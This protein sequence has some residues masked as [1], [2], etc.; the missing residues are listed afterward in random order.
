MRKQIFIAMFLGCVWCNICVGCQK[1]SKYGIERAFECNAICMADELADR[2]RKGEAIAPMTPCG[3][4]MHLLVRYNK[5]DA[6]DTLLA[7]GI[8]P[9]FDLFKEAIFYKRDRIVEKLMAH[10]P[11]LLQQQDGIG[12]P[13]HW[14]SL[15][16][17]ETLTR[18]FLCSGVNPNALNKY[19]ETP[20]HI[21]VTKGYSEIVRMLCDGG[22]NPFIQNYCFFNPIDK[23]SHR[24]FKIPKRSLSDGI[25]EDPTPIYRNIL[26][27]LYEYVEKFGGKVL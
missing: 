19:H 11:S 16:K 27:I 15:A 18:R 20:L 17:S 23:A 1:K 14:A 10:D 22:A 26:H 9:T 2:V 12:C 5:E 7:K 8:K 25:P 4:S 24:M 13:L 3:P 6:V 21:A